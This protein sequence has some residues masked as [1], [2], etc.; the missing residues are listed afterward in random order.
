[1][2][3]S[4]AAR[5]TAGL[6]STTSTMPPSIWSDVT[7]W[8][9]ETYEDGKEWAQSVWGNI[10]GDGA[11]TAISSH[12]TNH[13]TAPPPMRSRL[14]ISTSSFF[15]TAT[16]AS[17]Q[18]TP[19]QPTPV[20]LSS[21]LPSSQPSQTRASEVSSDHSAGLHGNVGMML[22]FFG[23]GVLASMILYL[24]TPVIIRF[25]QFVYNFTRIWISNESR[26]SFAG[27]SEAGLS[28]E[29]FSLTGNLDRGDQRNGLDKSAKL[30]ILWYMF[31]HGESFDESRLR[32]VHYQF[33]RNGIGTDGQPLDPK[34][35]R[36]T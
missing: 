36:T 25:C 18:P 32:Y 4:Q 35:R 27:D 7:N 34:F 10:K 33:A 24:L 5:H 2:S 11:S 21:S 3:A 23:A 30:R 26:G 31:I 14:D 17:V 28:S 22:L 6:W 15:V 20:M 1:M 9:E 29:A 16:G 8:A 12:R 19:V 13:E